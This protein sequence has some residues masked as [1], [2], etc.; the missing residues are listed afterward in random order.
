LLLEKLKSLKLENKKLITLLRDSERLFYQ[1]LQD[2]KREGQMLAGLF[3]QLWPLIQPKVRDPG[4]LLK[5]VTGMLTG[6]DL[7]EEIEE[8]IRRC[9]PS[10]E[11]EV[12]ELEG[13]LAQYK[14]R[15][16]QVREQLGKEQER[17]QQAEVQCAAVGRKAKELNAY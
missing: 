14:K 11:S 6:S 12:S 8:T 4:A 9:A 13:K 16:R 15:E 1:K 10:N 2:T 3:K 17:R 7:A 5:T